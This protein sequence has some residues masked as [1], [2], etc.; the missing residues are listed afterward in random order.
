M[1]TFT[2]FFLQILFYLPSNGQLWLRLL[3]DHKSRT[4]LTLFDYQNAFETYWKPFNV[5]NGY[6]LKDGVKHKAPGWKQFRRW[7]YMMSLKSNAVTGELPYFSA[8]EIVQKFEKQYQRDRNSFQ[9]NWKSLG[10]FAPQ[11]SYSGVGRINCIAFHPN[12]KNTYWVGAASGGL[13]VTRDNGNTWQCLTDKNESL[14]V[15]DIVLSGNYE[16]DQTLIIATGD[17]DSYDNYSEGVLITRDDGNTWNPTDIDYTITDRKFI[18]RIIQQYDEPEVLLA[19]T[20]DGVFK[21]TDFGTTWD[22][23][24]TDR[25]FIDMEFHPSNPMII[26]GST[27]TGQIYK[28]VNGGNNWTLAHFYSQS[29]RTELAVSPAQPDWLYAVMSA[30]SLRA[31]FQSKDAGT[32]FTRVLDGDTLNLLDFNSNGLGTGGQGY[33]DLAI[34]A[35]PHDAN[36]LFIG[37]INTWKSTDG[38]TRWTLSNYFGGNPNTDY[39]HAD[40]HALNFRNDGVLFEGNDGGIYQSVDEGSNWIDVTNGM[41]ISQMYKLGTSATEKDIVLTGLQDN[42]TKMNTPIAWLDVGGGDGMECIVDPVDAD[43]QYNSSQYG[44]IFRTLNRWESS[45]FIKPQ[46]AGSGNWVTPFVI[47]PQNPSTLYA[48]YSEIWKSTDRGDT[49]SQAS[50]FNESQKIRAIAVAPSDPQTIYACGPY[51]LYKSTGGQSFQQIQTL[52]PN[53]SNSLSYL[54]V[55]HDDPLTVWLTSSSYFTPGV[56]ESTDGGNTWFDI[57][58]GL[59][60]IPVYTIV[61]NI[62]SEEHIDLYCGTELGVYYKRDEEAWVP[63]NDA[64]PN[65]IVSELEFHYSSDP[66]QTLLRA[67]TYGRGLWETRVAFDSNPMEFVSS[68]TTHPTFDFI[69][70]GFLNQ[71]ILKIEIQTTG[72]IEPLHVTSFQFTTDGTTDPGHDLL[73]AKVY[74]TNNINGLLTTTLFGN[75]VD[76]PNG[77]FNISGDQPL[78]PGTN[79]FWLVY[80]LPPYPTEG[81]FADATCTSFEVNGLQVPEIISPEGNREIRVVYCDAGSTH[82]SQEHISNVRLGIIDQTSVK[83]ENGYEDN[84]HLIHPCNINTPFEVSVRN[85]SPHQ[86]NELFA[87]V[88]FNRDGDFEDQGEEVFYSGT[89][90]AS[91]YNFQITPPEGSHLGLTR[92][93]IRLHD[94]QFGPNDKPCLN[95]NLGEVEDYGLFI[96]EDVMSSVDKVDNNQLFIYPNPFK[97]SFTVQSKTTS[98][99]ITYSISD[100]NGTVIKSGNIDNSELIHMKEQSSGYYILT[101]KEFPDIQYKLVKMDKDE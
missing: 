34:A 66:N 68:T 17:R 85:S 9:S 92:M 4:E 89:G 51:R 62:Q 64:L 38:G 77:S 52:V 41:A 7:E 59:P 60:P 98:K 10:P 32:T 86:T 11:G 55:K 22:Q 56:F 27:G 65:V 84:T 76:S 40:K 95:S 48:G 20:G 42:G 61:Q 81:N 99:Q 23:L 3:P 75:V 2:L 1:R 69:R 6:Y 73:S 39:A 30:G 43:V 24:L 53:Q 57:S 35:S 25:I 16:N 44:N 36:I 12:D 71:E 87:W 90:V 28:S 93:R 47:D 49:W 100:L 26:Y 50:S 88:D 31:V 97:D 91:T 37:G 14:G 45:R 63:F 80:D 8:S 82:L 79:Y 19:A 15:S 101:L 83:G 96:S 33:Y 67:A 18:N 54:T 78:S 29:G 70:P 5:D 74:F 72:D 46:Q 58:E 94:S 21:S 13:W